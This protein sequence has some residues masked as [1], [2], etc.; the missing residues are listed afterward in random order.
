MSV[1]V[2]A[3]SGVELGAADSVTVVC[4]KFGVFSSIATTFCVVNP[5]PLICMPRY[6]TFTIESTTISVGDAPAFKYTAVAGVGAT[7][8]TTG[9]IVYP[10]PGSVIVYSVTIPVSKS[11]TGSTTAVTP[12]GVCGAVTLANRPWLYPLPGVPIATVAN[13]SP[14]SL[15]EN[16]V[17]VTVDPIT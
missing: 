10:V 5:V 11:I 16:C 12:P 14:N 9:G 6:I 7:T 1:N 13:D 3:P 15:T 17:A 2:T 8:V 4:A